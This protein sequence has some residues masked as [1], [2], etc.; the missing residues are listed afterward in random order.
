MTVRT[1][2]KMGQETLFE[3]SDE[4]KKFSTPELHALIQDMVDTMNHYKGVGISAPQIGHNQR[5]IIFGFESNERYP[6]E[7]PV[8]FTILINPVIYTLSDEKSEGFEGCLSV[9]G[10]RG[11]VSRF[12][13]IRYTGFDPEG[14]VIDRIAEDF[15]ARVVQHECDHIDGILFPMQITDMKKFGFESVLKF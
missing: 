5:I 3:H 10:L 13:K 12:K 7:K 6:K 9:P 4:I 11:V 2:L 8:P 14:N 1:V 15:H